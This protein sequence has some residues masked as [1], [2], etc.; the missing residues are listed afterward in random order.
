M[1]FSF[2]VVSLL[3]FIMSIFA[4]YLVFA[5][6]QKV[7]T[8]KHR[9]PWLYIGTAA[10]ALS[11]SELLRF[12]YYSQNY[13]VGTIGITEGIIYSLVFFSLGF[14]SY[15]LL[16]EYLILRFY[17]GK[18][19]KIKFIPVEEGSVTGDLDIDLSNGV[20]YLSYK[21][22]RSFMYEQFALATKQGF[23]GFLIS[24]DN[25][26][27]IR[28]KF[29][30]IK[31]PIAWLSQIDRNING[32]YLKD[33]LDENSDIVDPLQINNLIS[34]I[35]NFLDQSSNPLIVVDCNLLFRL[36]SFYI[37]LEFLKYI[38]TRT[39]RY[40]GVAIM[41]ISPDLL[42]KSELMELVQFLKILE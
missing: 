14:L 20:S 37:A 25:P 7:Y 32:N 9:K 10:I 42:K 27:E 21:H 1:A 26:I 13:I 2:S 15:G 17:K 40:N 33:S 29:K 19:V 39:Q 5:I 6:M 35:D 16:L 23:Q 28:K 22:D 12:F 31:T 34:F 4:I 38:S 41:M 30:L 36:N 11:L 8:E 24:E 18:F 3:S